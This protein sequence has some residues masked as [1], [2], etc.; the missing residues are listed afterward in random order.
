MK[1]FFHF[2]RI[3]TQFIKFVSV[4]SKNPSVTFISFK[5]I[6]PQS[7]S[8]FHS[9]LE[10][11]NQTLTNTSRIWMFHSNFILPT[12]LA[13]AVISETDNHLITSILST[14]Q[15]NISV[16]ISACLSASPQKI[17]SVT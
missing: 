13:S 16:I 10:V 7:I 6:H 4:I 15:N 12:S 11:T 3:T 1:F 2:L 9:H 17:S 8:F 14:S 5:N